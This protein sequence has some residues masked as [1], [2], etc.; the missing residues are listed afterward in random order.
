MYFAE[1]INAPAAITWE[2]LVKIKFISAHM[3]QH[4]TFRN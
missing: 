3:K 1:F 4:S 2:L